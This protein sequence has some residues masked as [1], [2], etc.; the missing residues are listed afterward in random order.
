MIEEVGQVTAV[1][2]SHAE[3]VI[4]RRSACGSC[5]AK[6]GCGTSL[7]AAWFPRRRLRFRLP[8]AIGARPG[9]RVVVGLAERRLQQASLALYG[10]P[11]G[12]LLLGAVGGELVAARMALNAELGSVLG[13][14]LGLIAGLAQVRRLSARQQAG[15]G[16]DVAILR[17]AGSAQ[18]GNL[19][20]IVPGPRIAGSNP[21]EW[22]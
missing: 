22:K 15:S 9:D 20:T 2:D 4:E 17:V 5:A 12:G 18:A 3:V 16:A 14:L 13:G 1:D 19:S 10:L 8:N 7:L 11:L 21:V 6:S